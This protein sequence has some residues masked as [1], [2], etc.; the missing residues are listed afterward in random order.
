VEALHRRSH[1]NGPLAVIRLA[2]R[3]VRRLL[4][5][6]LVASV[7]ALV[8]AAGID[9]LR[10]GGEPERPA[11]VEPEPTIPEAS[12]PPGRTLDQA[13]ADLREAGVPEGRLILWDQD[14]AARVLLLPDLAERP[15]RGAYSCRPDANSGGRVRVVVWPAGVAYAD[16]VRG[17]LRVWTERAD[18]PELYAAERG[19]GAAWKPDDTLSF[20]QDG[21]VRSFVRC[22]HDGATAPLRCSRS[23][24]TRAELAR[25][26]RGVPW[27][28]YK[29]SIKELRWLDNERFA[30]IM[31]AR[32]AGGASDYLVIVERGR[33]VREPIFAYADLGGI[34]PSPSGLLVA[35]YDR[36]GG[37]VVVADSAGES[38]QL[39]MDHGDGI[40]W[41]PDESWIAE[42]TEDGIYV[43]RADEDSPEFI[44]IPVVASDLL[45]EEP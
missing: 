22:P 2:V 23:V 11:T 16:C 13:E 35:A 26:L 44:Q 6:G 17:R 39:A 21:N 33:L 12:E 20:I 30:A 5:W 27:S 10:G 42:A 24:F 40:A 43:F 19:C 1:R 34:R 15:V 7:A 37:G 4:T 31:K 9:A 8:A 38:V 32:S 18:S 45:W 28:G 14:C 29:L 25:Q 3:T 41:S 36:G